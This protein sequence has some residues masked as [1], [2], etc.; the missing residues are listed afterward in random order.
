MISLT[1]LVNVN[2][3]GNYNIQYAVTDGDSNTTIKN[4]EVRVVDTTPPTITRTGNA[5]ITLQVG[6]TYSEQ[7]ATATDN[8]DTSVSVVVGG[9]TVDTTALGTYTITY[10]ASDTSNNA[11]TQVTRTVNVVDTT[12][13]TVTVNGTNPLI[14]PFGGPFSV[15]SYTTSDNSQGT[16][17][18]TVTDNV[19]IN[20]TGAYTVNYSASDPSGNTNSEVLMF[21]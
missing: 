21:T 8:Y 1:G 10:N 4:R 16:V 3:L 14:I 15:P 19:N 20:T 5:V 2:Q 17:T 13:P 11:A 12:P 18:V 7:S 9:D 6:D